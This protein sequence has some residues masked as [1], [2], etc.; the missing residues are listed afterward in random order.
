LPAA[1]ADAL[2][3]GAALGEGGTQASSVTAPAAPRP[4]VVVEPPRKLTAP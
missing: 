2:G 3:E 4:V 1:V